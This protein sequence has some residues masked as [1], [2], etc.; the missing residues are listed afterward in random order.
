MAAS[1]LFDEPGPKTRTRH[2]LYGAVSA[3]ILALLLA[4][5]LWQFW[6][7]GQF[8]PEL[9][10]PF[11][12]PSIMVLILEGIGATVLAA[13]FAI[14]GA[15][16]FGLVFG[17]AKLSDHG[18]VRRPAWLVVEFFRAVPL[19]MLII[20]TWY[21]VVGPKGG[22]NGFWALVIGLVLYNGAVF[23]EI[24]RAGVN[25]VPKGQ[26]E[27]AYA[28]GM[29]KSQVMRIILL[30]QAIK[31]MLPALIS[32]A[33]VALKDTSLGYAV[34]A[35]GLTY[36]GEAIDRTF[37]NTLPT[38]FVIAVIY[39]ILNLTLTYVATWA[40]KKFSGD[41]KVDAAAVGQVTDRSTGNS[42]SGA[43]TVL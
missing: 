12:T 36:A 29:S 16:A 22:A 20:A 3:A 24:F 31:I 2:R 35:T 37:Q 13:V 30:P 33:V 7:K 26:S 14:L 40:Q 6:R 8:E 10:E 1:V 23:S 21:I 25:A 39:I 27:A 4:L 43:G 28:I 15:L 32:Q 17:P 19:L 34:L 5:M 9:W 42:Q 41:D 18:L 38:Y 11:V